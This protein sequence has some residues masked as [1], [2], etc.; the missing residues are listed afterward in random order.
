[1]NKLIIEQYAHTPREDEPTD[2]PPVN[3]NTWN[4]TS[5]QVD[6]AIDEVNELG[7]DEI[8]FDTFDLERGADGAYYAENDQGV[9]R[10]TVVING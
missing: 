7:E 5:S 9:F 3:V 1:M 8:D 4:V 2:Y 10:L 6:D